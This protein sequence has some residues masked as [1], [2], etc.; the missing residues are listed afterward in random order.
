[1]W[2]TS[3]PPDVIE[4]TE[5]F[6]DMEEAFGISIDEDDCLELYDMDLDEAV[7]KIS[8]IIKQKR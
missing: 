6:R 8:D 7:S 3:D 5:P 2:S 1:M 4:D